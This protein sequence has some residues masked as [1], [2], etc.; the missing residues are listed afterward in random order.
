MLAVEIG[1]QLGL[2]PTRLRSLA[3]GGHTN[4]RTVRVYDAL[5]SLRVYR[6]AWPQEDALSLLRD[7]ADIAFD[8]RCNAA[9]KR[10]VTVE[11]S[12]LVSTPSR[13]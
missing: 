1:E 13:S 3:I 10:T 12:N 6:P 4:P 8:S 11:E 7:E 2:S 5:V 9:L